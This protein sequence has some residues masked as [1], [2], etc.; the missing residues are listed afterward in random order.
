MNLN[1]F[2]SRLSANAG[3]V[4]ALARNV[5]EAQ[6]RWKP[7]PESG[8]ILE[9]INHLY[10][11][12]REDF[13]RRIDYTLHKSGEQWPPIDPAGWV[14]ERGYNQRELSS[15]LEAFLHERQESL[16][17]LAGLQNSD[18]GLAYQHPRAGLIWAGDLLAAWVGHDHLHI[19]Q[20]NELHWQY[21]AQEAPAAA[22]SYAGEW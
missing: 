15:S 12:E 14:T 4:A 17:W 16:T 9:V 13:R 10:D 21:L 19:R 8:S 7:A 18:W 3:A 20:L 5:A 2:L 1:Y 6:A 22:L 11:E